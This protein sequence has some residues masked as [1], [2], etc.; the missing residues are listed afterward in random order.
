MIG[1][2]GGWAALLILS[3]SASVFGQTVGWGVLPESL[4]PASDAEAVTSD[5]PSPPAHQPLLSVDRQELGKHVGPFLNERLTYWR[6]RL[7]LGEWQISVVMTRRDDLKPKTLGKVR[8]DKHKKTAVIE[9]LDASDYSLLPSAILDDM[10]LTV[11][12]EL[13]HLELASLPRSE[14][15]R[16]SEEHAV[17]QIAEALV[18]LD[19]RPD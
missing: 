14:A 13:V 17:N 4:V 9:V 15:S 11:V 12:H 2:N 18:K 5:N 6:Q 3:A 19:R 7:N 16:S 1:R 8:W 10:E